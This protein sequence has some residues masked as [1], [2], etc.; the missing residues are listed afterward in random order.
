MFCCILSDQKKHGLLLSLFI[1]G[2]SFSWQH[3]LRYPVRG[4]Q[5]FS[6][7][8]ET[9]FLTVH[10]NI[11]SL[12]TFGI[13][14]G[15]IVFLT[16]LKLQ[17]PEQELMPIWDAGIIGGRFTHYPVVQAP[18]FCLHSLV[19]SLPCHMKFAIMIH[20]VIFFDRALTGYLRHVWESI[21]SLSQ[22][23][24]NLMILPVYLKVKK[25]LGWENAYVCKLLFLIWTIANI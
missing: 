24:A 9:E 5:S 23:G 11:V 10:G 19:P 7:T 15:S 16:G 2:L 13:L 14:S 20:I 21:S 12:L 18:G 1:W 8:S 4:K 6:L 17:Q 22:W 25:N 3:L